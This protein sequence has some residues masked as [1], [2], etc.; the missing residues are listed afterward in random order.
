[1]TFEYLA[2]NPNASLAEAQEAVQEDWDDYCESQGVASDG[3][4]GIGIATILK[5]V[6]L[7]YKLWELW[8][9]R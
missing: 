5:W 2:D 1:M 8:Q 7:A 4:V 3:G 6:R 9:D